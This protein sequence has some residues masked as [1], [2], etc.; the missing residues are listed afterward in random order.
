[1]AFI[2]AVILLYISIADV[3]AFISTLV[4]HR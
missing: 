3:S 2:L 4:S 1:V